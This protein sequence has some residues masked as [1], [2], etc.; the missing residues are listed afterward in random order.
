MLLISVNIFVWGITLACTSACGNFAGLFVTRFILGMCEGSVT[1]G[2]MIVTSMFYTRNEQT[3]RVGYWCECIS[4]SNVGYQ[5]TTLVVT[6]SGTGKP[7]FFY[8]SDGPE[9]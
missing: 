2:F 7:W 6:M 5:L 8:V 9:I 1:A 3:L 4:F